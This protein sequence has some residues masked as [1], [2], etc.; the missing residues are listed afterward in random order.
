MLRLPD[1]PVR[2]RREAWC[3]EHTT[4]LLKMVQKENRLLSKKQMS[5]S[6]AAKR[7]EAFVQLKRVVA[8]SGPEKNGPRF[9]KSHNQNEV[10]LSC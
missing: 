7:S 3:Q 5:Y 10:G 8:R 1:R 6:V 4:H 9:R 2:L